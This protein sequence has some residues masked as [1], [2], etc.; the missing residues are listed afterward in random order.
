MIFL[1][2]IKR[3]VLEAFRWHL[4]IYDAIGFRAVLSAKRENMVQSF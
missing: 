4:I 2:I 1:I 3:F